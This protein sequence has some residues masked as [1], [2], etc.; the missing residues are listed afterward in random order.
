MSLQGTIHSRLTS[1]GV[2]RLKETLAELDM[3]LWQ[4]SLT[5][6]QRHTGLLQILQVRETELYG[7]FVCIA[8]KGAQS[9]SFF[10][11]LSVP[12]EYILA[13]STIHILCLLIITAVIVFAEVP[14]ADNIIKQL[15][16]IDCILMT[17]EKPVLP[18]A[19]RQAAKVPPANTAPEPGETGFNA[20]A[21]WLLAHCQFM[22]TVHLDLKAG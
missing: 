21:T 1:A 10:W 7:I 3:C 15:I 9:N 18:Q 13:E 19:A 2:P 22:R 6:V 17:F 5:S 20:Q 11:H 4:I 8:R 16:D 14:E 12:A